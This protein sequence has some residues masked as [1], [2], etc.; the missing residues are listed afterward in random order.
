[1]LGVAV[2]VTNK[3]CATAGKF[4]ALLGMTG[5]K[6]LIN[7]KVFSDVC[8]Q[9]AGL[10]PKNYFCLLSILQ[11]NHSLKSCAN[12]KLRSIQPPLTRKEF[13]LI[14]IAFSRE[15]GWGEGNL[16]MVKK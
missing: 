12:F 8:P 3:D 1:M 11:I 10:L 14:F 7:R 13:E 9:G 6:C 16:L 15:E 2:G 4:L 5:A